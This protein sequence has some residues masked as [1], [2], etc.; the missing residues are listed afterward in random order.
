M[1]R[2]RKKKVIT[3]PSEKKEENKKQKTEEKIQQKS[4][5]QEASDYLVSLGYKSNVQDGV[6]RVYFE[7]GEGEGFFEKIGEILHEYGY[8]A[9]YGTRVA[10]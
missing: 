4:E 6:V 1:P 5:K 9:S 2:G 10:G 8:H 7:P 3:E